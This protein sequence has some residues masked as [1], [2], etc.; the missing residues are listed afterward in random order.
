MERP[1]ETHFGELAS[2]ERPAELDELTRVDEA[3]IFTG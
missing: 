1:W 2:H 3:F